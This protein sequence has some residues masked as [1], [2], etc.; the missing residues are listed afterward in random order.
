MAL[1]CQSLKNLA[2]MV[3]REVQAEEQMNSGEALLNRAINTYWDAC[4]YLDTSTEK[5]AVKYCND[6]FITLT[7]KGSSQ[8]HSLTA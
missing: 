5:W 7:G 6:A 3:A 1:M 2:E 4:L 8:H